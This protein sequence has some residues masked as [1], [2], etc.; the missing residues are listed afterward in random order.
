[1]VWYDFDMKK[2]VIFFALL[3]IPF[4]THA[5][6]TWEETQP[7]G[8]AN[9]NWQAAGISDDGQTI[10]AGVYGGRLYLSADGGD[11]WAETRPAGD[12]NVDWYD[13][14]VSGD[15]ETLLAAD[16][17]FSLGGQGRLYLSTDGGGSWSE[18][19]P[20][21]AVLR[22]WRAVAANEDGSVLVAAHSF[23]PTTSGVYISTDGGGSWTEVFPDGAGVKTWEDSD[24][25]ADG[26]YIVMVGVYGE[27]HLSTNGGTDW[28]DVGP[29][30]DRSWTG[31]AMSSDGQTIIINDRD[32]TDD[33]V[34][35][36]TNSGVD[37]IQSS[38]SGDPWECWHVGLDMDENGQRILLG[39]DGGRIY[40]TEDG[41]TVWY[42]TQPT[43]VGVDKSWYAVAVNGDGTVF[44][45][46]VA[47]GRLYL[48]SNPLPDPEL[49][50]TKVVVNNDGGTAVAGDFS[51]TLNGLA[52]TSGLATTTPAG[53]YT[54][55]ETGPGDYTGTFS[56]DC[57]ADG[58]I[59][60]VADSTYTCTL[61]NDD[62][63]VEEG[64]GGGGSSSRRRFD[65]EYKFSTT[66]TTNTESVEDTPIK[67]ILEQLILVLQQLIQ[68]L[69]AQR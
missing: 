13:V 65:G 16:L 69:I 5:V 22:S 28:V 19:Q 23:T 44:V 62:V 12:V 57:A 49:T 6:I 41:G 67:T 36:T 1:M 31:V 60:M 63:A 43:G 26:G 46:G 30:E 48:G 47:G 39:G 51:L 61:T 18:T 7:A 50:V 35:I 68:Q 38:V 34:F 20:A 4:F 53:S 10:L 9:K 55:A 17:N 66:T 24:I 27:I 59:T 52:I 11:S 56:G 45:T 29:A 8:D 14:A 15:G 21:G 33:T 2:Y 54:V 25:S 42:E 58:T 3:A 32:C 37:W 40:T 64:G